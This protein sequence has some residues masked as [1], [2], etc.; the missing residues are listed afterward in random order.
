MSGWSDLVMGL[1]RVGAASAVLAVAAGVL[2][3]PVGADVAEE[4]FHPKFRMS[5]QYVAVTAYKVLRDHAGSTLEGCASDVKTEPDRFADL[6]E[7]GAFTRGAINCLDKQGYLGGLPGGSG[8]GDRRLFEPGYAMSK[9]YVAVTVY[10]VLRDHARSTLEGCASEVKAEPDRFGDLDTAAAFTRGAIN[11]LDKQGYLDGLPTGATAGTSTTTETTTAYTDISAGFGHTCAVRGDGTVICWGDNRF[12]QADAPS[13]SFASVSAG[14]YQSCGVRAEGTVACW[15]ADDPDDLPDGSLDFGQADAPS[16]SFASVSAGAF[17]TCGVRS[18]GTV[19][20]WGDNRQGE[21]DAPSGSFVSVSA[22][23]AHSC[24]VRSG[25]T[26]I[27]WGRSRE[28]QAD[29]PSGSFTSVSAGHEHSC[30]VRSGGTAACWGDNGNGKADA[31]SGSFTAVSAGNEYSCG[32]R[33][34]GR[35]TCWGHN[36]W[37]SWS[38]QADALSGSFTSVSA[39]QWHT[40]GVHSDGGVACW[41]WDDYGKT[42]V[43]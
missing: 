41:G 13:G 10:K 24:G 21:A 4:S 42:Q 26:V 7:A 34:D 17:H 15:G 28:G 37:T 9:Q 12:G 33:R 35:V 38:E 22:G 29:A 11:C 31:P 20:C 14:R 36:Y 5:K 16:G 27:C 32:V 30:G 40:C 39:G 23:W 25:G 1:R 8:E 43:P 18:S 6:G 19:I 3:V 2:A